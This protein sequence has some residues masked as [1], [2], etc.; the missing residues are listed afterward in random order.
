MRDPR[1]IRALGAVVVAGLA[2]AAV[3]VAYLHPPPARTPEPQREPNPSQVGIVRLAEFEVIS[4]KEAWA[5]TT[6]PTAAGLRVLHTTDGG[7]HW[8]GSHVPYVSG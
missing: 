8:A 2:V 7:E 6:E 5:L 1:R 4:A 3:A